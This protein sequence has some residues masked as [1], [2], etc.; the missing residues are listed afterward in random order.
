MARQKL[1]TE[2]CEIQVPVE[3]S[4]ARAARIL[5]LAERFRLAFVAY[6][7]AATRQHHSTSRLHKAFSTAQARLEYAAGVK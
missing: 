6:V 4:N 3:M 2:V 7:E 1:R 5:V